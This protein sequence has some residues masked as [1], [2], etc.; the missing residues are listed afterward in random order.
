MIVGL[1]R[2][3]KPGARHVALTPARARTVSLEARL[4]EGEN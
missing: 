2:E 1:P 4:G 3:I